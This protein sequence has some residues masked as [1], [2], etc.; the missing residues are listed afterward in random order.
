MTAAP[1]EGVGATF[2]V[3]VGPVAHGGH[4]VARHQGR[5]V[6]VRHALPGERV[7]VQITDTGHD[8]FW[9][10]DAVEV[11]DPDPDRVT[12][13]CPVAGPGG[14]GGCDLQHAAPAAQRRLKAAVLAEQLTRLGGLDVDRLVEAAVWS[15]TVDALPDPP[16]APGEGL[17][18]RTRVHYRAD[19]E[20]RPAM[21]AHRSHEL[22]PLPAEGCRIAVPELA[23]PPHAPAEGVRPSTGPAVWGVGAPDGRI[24]EEVGGG[25]FGLA[26]AGFWQ[27]HPAAAAL[28]QRT[29]VTALDP[30]PGESALDLYCGVGLFAAGLLA[31]GC[32]PVAGVEAS[33]AAVDDARANL[34]A[35]AGADQA[36]AV[37]LVAGR[38]DR[39]LGRRG[40]PLDRRWD[41]VVLDPPRS[42]AGR[43]VVEQVVARRP[44]AVGYVACDPAALGRDLATFARLGYRLAG[45]RA[46]DLFPMTQHL[47]AVAT[48]VRD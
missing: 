4:C 40:G 27:V 48:L 46:F 28:L 5:V 37:R 8:R 25:R 2:E 22:V 6:F 14:C 19:A 13:P 32:D 20:G 41:L 44:R 11:L 33:R 43:A 36:P 35:A 39:A 17:G 16:G 31:A 38:V 26:A 23:R 45:L 34:A 29:V 42:G 1:G 18:W 10:G 30:Q 12:P 3:E 7:R 24:V 15:G 9:R 21:L 47:E